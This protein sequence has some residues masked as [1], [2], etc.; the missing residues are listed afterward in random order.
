MNSFDA[1]PV[2]EEDEQ[3]WWTQMEEEHGMYWD[4]VNGDWL[5][6]EEVRKARKLELEWMVSKNVFE[7]APRTDAQGKILTMRWV[8]TRTANGTYRSRL[9]VLEIKALKKEDKLDPEDI[10]SSMP[11][12]EA[13]KALTSHMMTEQVNSRGE[14]LC[15][16]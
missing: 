10:F 11:P 2:P 1:G 7:K 14:D 8:D 13:L 6:P 9:V 12:R 4:D 16:A 5:D 15:M 3:H